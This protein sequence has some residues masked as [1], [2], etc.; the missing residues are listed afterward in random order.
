MFLPLITPEQKTV[1]TAV[2]AT[3]LSLVEFA[4][5]RFGMSF[6]PL[7]QFALIYHLQYHLLATAFVRV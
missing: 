6:L 5:N 1:R 4:V 3:S 7:D 2:M